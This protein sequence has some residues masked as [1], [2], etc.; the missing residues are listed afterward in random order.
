MNIGVCGTG[1][2]ASWISSILN[3]LQDENIRLYACA[4]APG[5]D[6][7]EF[8]E[9]FHW[10]KICR[11]YDEL[12]QDPLVDV[13]Y[14]AVPNN[15]HYELCIKALNYGK[16]VIC[17][18]P[19]AINE[20]ECRKILELAE[21]KGL[22][23]T[24]ALWPSFLPAH[25][26]IN[27]EIAAGTIGEVQSGN[28]VM[29]DFVMFLERVKVLEAGG[30]SLMDG[31]PYTIGCMTN[32]FGTD[33]KSVTS[34]TRKLDTGV[35]AEDCITVEY[36][37][38]KVVTIRQTID[39]PHENHEEY[40]EII[41]SKGKI[42]GDCVSNPKNVT[43]FDTEGNVKKE[44]EIPAQIKNQGMPPV[45]GYEYEFQAFEK[46]LREGKTECAEI[47]HS[48]TLTISHIM[49]EVRRQAGIVFPFE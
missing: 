10:S 28:I 46:A 9:K 40:F 31:G 29:L 23:I 26:M 38:G 22:F 3:Q 16:P 20:T 19:F 1:T 42:L 30:G 8:A 11:D 5:F 6:C 43:I 12:M 34:T 32:H 41:G 47:P 13:V 17:E 35:D 24:E 37:D 45:S 4:T 49:T 33:I 15:F 27:E 25:K 21:E 18:K 14:I 39:M 44:L 36:N 7:S 48:E 2:I